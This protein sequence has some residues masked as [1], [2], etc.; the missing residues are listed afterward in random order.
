VSEKSRDI[1][2]KSR[3]P[4]GMAPGSEAAI[5]A[6]ARR[7]NGYVTRRQLI[8]LG[9]GRHAIQYRIRA[10]RLITVYAGVYAVG[11]L[12]TLPIDRAAGAVLACGPAA[13]LSH[14]SAMTLWG[15]WKRWD[16]PFEVTASWDFRRRGIRVH[17]AR[18]LLRK[19]ARKH[20]GI[21]VTSP[22]RTLL[23][24]APRLTDKRLTR[25]VNNLFISNYL[26]IDQLA[27]L[28]GRSNGHAAAARLKS[29]VEHPTGPT[30]S[31]FEDAFRAFAARFGLPPAECNARFTGYEVD[32]L[33]RAQRVIVELDSW[34]FHGNRTAFESDRDRDAD[35]L[36]AG[37]KTVRIT[38]DRLLHS[39]AR[40]AE[41]LRK[42]LNS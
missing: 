10:G 13:V 31:D 18:S 11:H 34:G 14:G 28:L 17:E 21:R 37:A 7:Q 22:A 24:I 25:A 41:R 27:E 32:A 38:W 42:I 30:R 19:D 8:D 4:L 15:V 9:L 36:A 5:A 35:T 6:V 33:F 29:F 3:T 2:G 26:R 20:L 1:G 12:P 23:D 16:V 39:S 40:E